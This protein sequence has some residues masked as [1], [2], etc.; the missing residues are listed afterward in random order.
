MVLLS[1]FFFFIMIQSTLYRIWKRER[2]LHLFAFL[3]SLDPERFT[4]GSYRDTQVEVL[5]ILKK[6]KNFASAVSGSVVHL[7]FP[8]SGSWWSGHLPKSQVPV[9]PPAT[10]VT[11]D[12]LSPNLSPGG[13][14]KPPKTPFT[15]GAPQTLGYFFLFMPSLGEQ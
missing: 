3:A 2:S 13:A 15:S 8:V 11:W 9:G 1:F 6:K 7:P 10:C 12:R 14:R 5:R 4:L